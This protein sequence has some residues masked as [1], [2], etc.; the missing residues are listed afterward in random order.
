MIPHRI[1]RL[2]AAAAGVVLALVAT[3][4]AVPPAQAAP[5][6]STAQAAASQVV[7]FT[8][9][10]DG[11]LYLTSS[12]GVS[13]FGPTAL[14]PPDADVSAVRQSDGNTAVFTV[15]TQGGLVAAVTSSATSNITVYRDGAGNL[16]PPGGRLTAFTAPDGYV[17][18]FFV[19]VD[20]AVYSTSYSRV[21]RPGAGPQRVS[22]PGVA[23]PGAVVAGS[24]QSSGPGA[25]FVGVDGG[26]RHLARTGG[27]WQTSSVGPSGVAAAGSGV[28]S[29][30]G[31]GVQAYYAGLDGRLW[32]VSPAGG[33]L[34]DPWNRV[35]VSDVGVVPVGAALAATRPVDGPT[36]VYFA[37]AA[38]AVRIVTNVAGGWQAY[39]VT[40]PAFAK[41]GGSI[42]V[43]TV[44]DYV[45][46]GWCGNDLWWWLFWWWRRPP[47]PPPP[48]L[49]E[50]LPVPLD[51][52]IQYGANV[53][54]TLYR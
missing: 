29:L 42:S 41:P 33:G 36:G 26:L 21:V 20:G 50:I 14:A 43:L 6:P 47:P 19:G 23:P 39:V 53:S 10:Q 8:V 51:Y 34:P 35:A 31:G 7:G 54:L 1:G 13:P 24:W 30:A 27:T 49:G 22:V 12:T 5:P 15:G 37:D 11:R 48:P 38:G 46:A 25:F 16:A 52:P 9:G 3:A 45:Y 44:G 4:A 28:A 32:Q 2:R 40:G 17:Y 18:V